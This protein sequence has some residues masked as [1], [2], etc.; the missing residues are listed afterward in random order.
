MMARMITYPGKMRVTFL[1][2][3]LFSVHYKLSSIFA[4][5]CVHGIV[6]LYE[7]KENTSRTECV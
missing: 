1:S 5:D 6:L 2:G 7:N 4:M 3:I